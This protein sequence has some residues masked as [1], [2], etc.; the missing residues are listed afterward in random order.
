[1]GDDWPDLP[2]RV[3]AGLAVAAA[4]AHAEVK[5]IAHHVS[6]LRGGQGA[7]RECCDLLLMEYSPKF[8]QGA[9][10]DVDEPV[11]LLVGAG[12]RPSVFVGERLRAV[13]PAELRTVA[14]QPNVIWSRVPLSP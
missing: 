9:G 7:A 12:L 11:D 6:A 8:M 2:L 3:R 1:M 13:T 14:R 4:N 10:L 5:A